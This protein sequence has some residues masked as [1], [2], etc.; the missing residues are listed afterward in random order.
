MVSAEIVADSLAPCGTRLTTFLLVYPRFIHSEL[1]THRQ[2][3][4]NSASSRAVPIGKVIRGVLRHPARPVQWGANGKGM[5]ARAVLPRSRAACANLVWTLACWAACAFSWVLYKFGVHKQIANRLTEPFAH[6]TTLVTATEWENFFALRAHKDAQPE[7]QALADAMLAAYV[8][9]APVRLNAG[10]WHL[11]FWRY[12]DARRLARERPETLSM[13]VD[14][15]YALILAVCT[16]R[17]ARTSYVN[18][19]GRDSFEDD[20]RLHTSLLTAG[21]MSPFEH[22]A[23]AESEPVRSGNFVGFTQYRKTFPGESRALSAGPAGLLSERRRD[24]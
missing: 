11:P 22:C 4:R 19:Y 12:E 17:C 1:L 10:D 21:H 2:F 7:F 15:W 13:S 20:L 24:G 16:A 8:A 9:S 3:S 23:R 6:M 18:F 14:Q 5:Q